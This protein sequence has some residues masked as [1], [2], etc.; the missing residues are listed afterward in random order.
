MQL[1]CY[2]HLTECSHWG[3]EGGLV[4]KGKNKQKN[5]KMGKNFHLGI[6][7]S[8]CPVW[9][10]GPCVTPFAK[11]NPARF[12]STHKNSSGTVDNSGRICFGKDGPNFDDFVADH[13]CL[14]IANILANS[15]Y[16][17]TII[18]TCTGHSKSDS[19]LYDF[20]EFL[21]LSFYFNYKHGL[22]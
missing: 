13:I 18:T 5:G 9:A 7:Y 15:N 3:G 21:I 1:V 2:E 12:K 22:K 17:T 10:G 11:G 19:N 6:D 4:E 14:Y 8:P 16:K 20:S